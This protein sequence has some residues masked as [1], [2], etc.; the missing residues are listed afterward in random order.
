MRNRHEKASYAWEEGK[1]LD[2]GRDDLMGGKLSIQ[3]RT[4]PGGKQRRAD[5][6]G[7]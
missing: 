7:Q 4:Q 3:I 2:G 5:L 6:E 1:N